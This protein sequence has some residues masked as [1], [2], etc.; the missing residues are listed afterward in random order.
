MFNNT[1]ISFTADQD[2]FIAGGMEFFIYDEHMCFDRVVRFYE[3]SS[4]IVSGSS[5]TDILTFIKG[6]YQKLRS[7]GTANAVNG[8]AQR[9]VFNYRRFYS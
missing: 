6:V 4:K 8:D 2:S 1:L 7:E 5:V 3:L 9:M